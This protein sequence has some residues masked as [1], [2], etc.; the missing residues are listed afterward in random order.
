MVRG[1]NTCFLICFESQ[2]VEHD[3]KNRIKNII[4]NGSYD[5]F[6]KSDSQY[7]IQLLLYCEYVR[8][9]NFGPLPCMVCFS[10]KVPKYVLRYRDLKFARPA[11]TV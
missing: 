8:F 9:A 6:K 5:F 4:S 3:A 11:Y 7:I 2:G 1:Q 10:K